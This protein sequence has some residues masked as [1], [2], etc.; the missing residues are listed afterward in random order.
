MMVTMMVVMVMVVMMVTMIVVMVNLGSNC[1]L[2]AGVFGALLLA[3][4]CGCN[5]DDEDAKHDDDG[6]DD[7]D[8]ISMIR[9][10]VEMM[11]MLGSMMIIIE[12]SDCT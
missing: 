9:I 4:C 6:Q 1:R 7:E 11:K 2:Q 12:M 5:Q 8:A 10:M 3:L